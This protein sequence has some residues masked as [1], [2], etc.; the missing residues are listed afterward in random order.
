MLIQKALFWTYNIVFLGFV[1]T[2]QG[3]HVGE[4]KMKAIREWLTPKTNG[5]VKV[6]MNL[7]AST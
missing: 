1:V 6:F 4:E 3:I 5:E 2:S 7:L